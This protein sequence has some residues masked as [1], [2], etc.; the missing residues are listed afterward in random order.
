MIN[1]LGLLLSWPRITFK[2][3][4]TDLLLFFESEQK[5]PLLELISKLLS[6]RVFFFCNLSTPCLGSQG[7]GGTEWERMAD[8]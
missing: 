8:R 1:T 5:S 6:F 4:V 7:Q 3:R 2:H